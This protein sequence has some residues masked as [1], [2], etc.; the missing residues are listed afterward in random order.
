M[1]KDATTGRRCTGVC[2][3]VCKVLTGDVPQGVLWGMPEVRGSQVC[4][5]VRLILWYEPGDRARK[6]NSPVVVSQSG[7][8][9]SKK[10]K[11]RGGAARATQQAKEEKGNG[12]L[13]KQK[14]QRKV[15][16]RLMIDSF[17]VFGFV[18]LYVLVVSDH[19]I[20]IHTATPARCRRYVPPSFLQNTKNKNPRPP[21]IHRLYTTTPH[22]TSPPPASPP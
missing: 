20:I 4:L 16:P 18:Q 6:R 13:E 3:C 11:R 8:R 1:A 14:E 7:A 21:P 22:P 17:L 5:P 2:V 9:E 10:M 19:P 15:Y 12:K